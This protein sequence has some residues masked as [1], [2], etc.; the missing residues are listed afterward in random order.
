MKAIR[1][2]ADYATARKAAYPDIGDQL[3]AIHKLL[4][5]IRR[6]EPAPAEALAVLDRVQAVKA[7][8]PK[9][10]KS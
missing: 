2:D 9:P 10:S 8:Y 7:T 6:S 3:D 5:A 1:I 4:D